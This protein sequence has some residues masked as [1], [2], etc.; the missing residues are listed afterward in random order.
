MSI[1]LLKNLKQYF[2][3]YESLNTNIYKSQQS[4]ITL[5]CKADN[6]DNFRHNGLSNIMLLSK[7][8]ISRSFL[9]ISLILF[10]DM[11]KI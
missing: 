10:L 5:L 1:N 7:S 3:N 9:I 2:F 8:L 4:S 6:M 11:T